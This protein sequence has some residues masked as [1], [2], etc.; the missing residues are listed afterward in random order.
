M[1]ASILKIFFFLKEPGVNKWFLFRWY[2]VV[3]TQRSLC[4]LFFSD[5]LFIPVAGCL[6]LSPSHISINRSEGGFHICNVCLVACSILNALIFYFFVSWSL[7]RPMSFCLQLTWPC[8]HLPSAS[9]FPP[10][11]FVTPWNGQFNKS[12]Q[13]R[14]HVLGFWVNA[15]KKKQW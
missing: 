8:R 12:R 13:V 6:S 3:Q 11:L 4:V 10:P 9:T 14:R 15:S 2:V 7:T 1:D 5:A